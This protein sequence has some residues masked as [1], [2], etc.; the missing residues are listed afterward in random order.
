MCGDLVNHGEKRSDGA[1]RRGN[2][3]RLTGTWSAS[4]CSIQFDQ[5]FPQL[6]YTHI[7]SLKIMAGDLQLINNIIVYFSLAR[8]LS[9]Y[10]NEERINH[11]V[12]SR[13]RG[14]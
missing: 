2:L 14:I 4:L 7:R 13:K 11:V 10:V 8:D 1:F 12:S 5:L 3:C 6:E 9:G